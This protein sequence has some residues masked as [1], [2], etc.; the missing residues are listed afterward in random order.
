M[1]DHNDILLF[2]SFHTL[3]RSSRDRSSVIDCNNMTRRNGNIYVAAVVNTNTSSAL[4]V[5]LYPCQENCSGIAFH[6][7]TNFLCVCSE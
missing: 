4:S 2:P 6:S 1:S 7:E 5:P 3:V